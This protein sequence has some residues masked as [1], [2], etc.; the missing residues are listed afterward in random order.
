MFILKFSSR[1]TVVCHANLTN[2]VQLMTIKSLSAFKDCTAKV[3][4]SVFVNK[5]RTSLLQIL[6]TVSSSITVLCAVGFTG[7]AGKR[8]P[9]RSL[10]LILTLLDCQ[11][12]DTLSIY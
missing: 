12:L 7:Q 9:K 1:N 6:T 10:T 4:N 2:D 11:S 8:L 5:N 3:C